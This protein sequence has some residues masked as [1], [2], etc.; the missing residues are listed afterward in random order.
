MRKLAILVFILVLCG[1]TSALTALRGPQ[2]N[3]MDEIRI[4]VADLKHALHGA[5]VEIKLLEERFENQESYQSTWV[6]DD[7][8]TLQKRLAALEKN[9]DKLSHD[10]RSLVTFASQTTAALSQYKDQMIEMNQRLQPPRG[11]PLRKY[12]VL[13]GDSLAKIALK[14]SVTID[15]LKQ[16]NRLASDK[17]I[18][19]QQLTIP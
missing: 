2:N 15:A 10:V 8:A 1:C 18:I 19:G 6:S 12:I 17:I 14:H 9:I 11:M 13:P 16:V 5:E 7:V 3:G 4:E